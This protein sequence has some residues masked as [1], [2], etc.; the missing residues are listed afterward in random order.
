MS[1]LG[2][3]SLLTGSV[4]KTAIHDGLDR[5]WGFLDENYA[6]VT[7]DDVISLFVRDSLGRRV[8]DIQQF[9]YDPATDAEVGREY[10]GES[11]VVVEHYPNGRFVTRRLRRS[12]PCR[13]DPR[14]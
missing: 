14:S 9:G 3:S 4:R 13:R 5:I 6:G 7:D 8:R 11:R 2:A 10:Q 12:R 1:H